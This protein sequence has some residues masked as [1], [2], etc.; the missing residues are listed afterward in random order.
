MI[1]FDAYPQVEC[2]AWAVR[3]STLKLF[4]G[5][6]WVRPAIGRA[7]LPTIRL[8][9]GPCAARGSADPGCWGMGWVL[10]VDTRQRREVGDPTPLVL[11]EA[12]TRLSK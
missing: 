3:W 10:V 1:S 2:I 5:T 11:G 7:R 12:Y 8:S 6:G 4:K 9:S